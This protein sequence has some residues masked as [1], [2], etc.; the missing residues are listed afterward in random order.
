LPVGY[1]SLL[2]RLL[3]SENGSGK[4]V[5]AQDDPCLPNRE[6][7]HRI[8]D[9]VV[10]LLTE[11]LQTG[12]VFK[13]LVYDKSFDPWT[14]YCLE[15]LQKRGF[16]SSLEFQF[17]QKTLNGKVLLSEKE[18]RANITSAIRFGFTWDVPNILLRSLSVRVRDCQAAHN[19][20]GHT[21]L[22]YRKFPA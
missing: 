15:H 21:M 12:Y 19:F 22:A 2:Q 17:L 11:L 14:N 20:L 18:L 10:N 9:G 13:I 5:P 1:E 6:T 7:T 8:A 3:Q 16:S 4:F